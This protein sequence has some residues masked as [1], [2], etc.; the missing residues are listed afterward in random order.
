MKYWHIVWNKE[1]IEQYRQY[2]EIKFMETEMT[3]EEVIYDLCHKYGDNFNWHMI[4]LTNHT[5]VKELKREI[6]INHFLYHEKV[7]AVAKC[8]SNDDVLYVSG[9]QSAGKDIYYIFHLTWQSP[10]EN[11]FPKYKEFVG[12]DAVRKYIENLCVAE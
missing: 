10:N 7:W 5:F 11:S 9:R 1:D 12:I 4:P 3:A 6:G 8:D 2:I